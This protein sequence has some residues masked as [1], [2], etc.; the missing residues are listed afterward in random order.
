[1]PKT[2]RTLP[3]SSVVYEPQRVVLGDRRGPE[4]GVVEDRP[5]VARGDQRRRQVGLP[6]ALGEPRATRSP[7]ERRLELVRHPDQL[8]DPIAL[9][10]RGE[11]RLVPA[12]ADDLDLAA[13]DEARRGGR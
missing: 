4:M 10:Q 8:A 7:A 2:V 5:V 11:D 3:W 1:M 6:D 9:R 12:P 13:L